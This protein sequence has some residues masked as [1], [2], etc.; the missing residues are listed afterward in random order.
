MPKRWLQGYRRLQR[1]LGIGISNHRY[2]PMKYDNTRSS[3]SAASIFARQAIVKGRCTT[4]V[5]PFPR[6]LHKF[7][8]SLGGHARYGKVLVSCSLRLPVPAW[9]RRLHSPTN[10]QQGHELS[11]YGTSAP[12]FLRSSPLMLCEADSWVGNA[13]ADNSSCIS[14]QP[15]CG[16]CNKMQCYH[17]IRHRNGRQNDSSLAYVLLTGMQCST[18]ALVTICCSV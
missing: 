3:F 9:S 13:H 2:Q 14:T 5:A 1:A 8:P 18:T 16:D 17:A 7:T 15:H 10:A 6:Q 4:A 11:K 12:S